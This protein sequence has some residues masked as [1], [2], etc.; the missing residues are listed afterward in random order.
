MGMESVEIVLWAE[1]EFGIDIPDAEAAGLVTIGEFVAYL[2]TKTQAKHASEAP[3]ETEI[4]DKLAHLLQHEYD[5]PREWIRP[6]VS[7][8]EDLGLG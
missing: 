5:V 7:F 1:Q 4:F 8:Y 6:E 3:A 2:R